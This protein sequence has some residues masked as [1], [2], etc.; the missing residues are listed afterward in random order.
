MFICALH[1]L[2]Q[3]QLWK[4]GAVSV[5]LA[6]HCGCGDL[7]NSLVDQGK[8]LLDLALQYWCQGDKPLHISSC[9]AAVCGKYD[10]SP[11]T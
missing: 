4:H 2:A 3:S 11:C 10:D 9:L 8:A 6:V 7:G 5:E 1:K